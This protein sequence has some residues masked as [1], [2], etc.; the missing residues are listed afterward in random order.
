MNHI[1]SE[2][3]KSFLP[4]LCRTTLEFTI[5][6]MFRTELYEKLTDA[7]LKASVEP[8]NNS[9]HTDEALEIPGKGKVDTDHSSNNSKLNSCPNSPE[10]DACSGVQI[11]ISNHMEDKYSQV[12]WQFISERYAP[13]LELLTQVKM[14]P[15]QF[16][17]IVRVCLIKYFS[18]LLKMDAKE[19][20]KHCNTHKYNK[21]NILVFVF[22]LKIIA[23]LSR[24][25]VGKQQTAHSAHKKEIE[26]LGAFKRRMD[27][28]LQTELCD[29]YTNDSNGKAIDAI[30]KFYAML[31]PE[32]GEE[33]SID[34]LSKDA[35]LPV[36]KCARS[37]LL[38]TEAGD[39]LTKALDKI[40]DNCVNSINSNRKRSSKEFVAQSQDPNM[41][42]QSIRKKRSNCYSVLSELNVDNE[43][44]PVTQSM[45]VFDPRR[46]DVV[47]GRVDTQKFSTKYNK[48]SSQQQAPLGF[49][50]GGFDSNPLLNTHKK[51]DKSKITKREKEHNDQCP[52]YSPFLKREKSIKGRK[53]MYARKNAGSN[54][55]LSNSVQQKAKMKIK[56]GRAEDEKSK[57]FKLTGVLGMISKQ[58][59]EVAKETKNKPLEICHERDESSESVNLIPTQKSVLSS[60]SRDREMKDESLCMISE[61]KDNSTPQKQSN[62]DV[63]LCYNTPSKSDPM[64]QDNKNNEFDF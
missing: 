22:G 25:V 17:P 28:T 21:V 8:F 13:Y 64:S 37:L 9:E 60:L 12:L 44:S 43:S 30:L 61:E 3:I 7:S 38:N 45:G 32:N 4:Y 62:R 46:Q 35:N 5:E 15:S 19:V 41:L 48:F 36:L 2:N 56:K 14:A 58:S 20:I 33:L 47:V 34:E 52:V 31:F 63:V 51:Q 49:E 40:H 26:Q 24:G 6:S 16:G 55:F 59:F 53:S 1:K 42:I 50:L 39:S 29:K 23:L 57:T 10:R 54:S 18:D 27:I 11:Q